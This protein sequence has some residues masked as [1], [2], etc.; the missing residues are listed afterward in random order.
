MERCSMIKLL[1][2]SVGQ[3]KDLE[4]LI[5]SG[6]ENLGTLPDAILNLKKLKRLMLD[7]CRK[8]EQLP[9]E[10]GNLFN[11]EELHISNCYNLYDLL[12]SI[13]GLI[14]LRVLHVGSTRVKNLPEDSG[15]LMCLTTLSMSHPLTV[16]ESFGR[17]GS[18]AFLDLRN[19]NLEGRLPSVLGGLTAL[20][21]LH[22]GCNPKI[23][24][25]PESFKNLKL[26]VRLQMDHCSALLTIEAL[27]PGLQHLNIAHCSKLIDL[28]SFREMSSLMFLN[29][30]NCTALTHIQGLEFLTA[31]EEIN[32]TGCTSIIQSGLR[33]MHSSALRLCCLSGSHVAVAYD[34]EWSKVI[35]RPMSLAHCMLC[36]LMC[37][38]FMSKGLGLELVNVLDLEARLTN[39]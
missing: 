38:A 7:G 19:C 2:E 13:S 9:M 8:L 25:L 16:P 35:C 3:L 22:L 32:L 29:M 28:P 24:V 17:L 14:K 33:V 15:Q 6:S 1:P 23:T 21:T 11:L 18:L 20:K 30:C 34:S 37:I 10:L 26:L 5:L 27:P 12:S 39:Q 36:N 31:L 4:H